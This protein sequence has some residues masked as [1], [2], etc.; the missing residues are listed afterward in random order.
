M[1]TSLLTRR[2][3]GA[4]QSKW[5]GH[6]S[7]YD[8]NSFRGYDLNPCTRAHHQALINPQLKMWNTL[9]TNDIPPK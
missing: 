8:A 4:S 3:A 2:F 1:E 7:T 5:S 9:L 6:F